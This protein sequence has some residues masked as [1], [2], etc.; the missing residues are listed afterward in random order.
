VDRPNSMRK[1]MV[2]PRWTTATDAAFTC[3][4][5]GEHPDRHRGRIFLRID[6]GRGGTTFGRW[7]S[8]PDALRCGAP[9]P[10]PPSCG[11]QVAGRSA[12]HLAGDVI[13][14]FGGGTSTPGRDFRFAGQRASRERAKL[15]HRATAGI[16]HFGQNGRTR[17]ACGQPLHSL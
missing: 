13:R 8:A 5:N 12:P 10:A 16:A 2:S 4:S 15:A 14:K 3:S 7:W 9:R 11:R 6:E 17:A 1:V